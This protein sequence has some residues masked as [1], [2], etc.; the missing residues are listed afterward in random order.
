MAPTIKYFN[1]T[2]DG[3]ILLVFFTVP[4]PSKIEYSDMFNP[5]QDIKKYIKLCD[6][7]IDI[8]NIDKKAFNIEVL[9]KIF[10]IFI[11]V[12]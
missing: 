2:S 9:F 12:F 7:S 3:P 4:A 1:T 11:L 5:T 10:N 8:E 6:N